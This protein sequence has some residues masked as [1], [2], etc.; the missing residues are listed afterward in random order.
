M[1]DIDD[2][3]SQGMVV[4]LIQINGDLR[5]IADAAR[6]SYASESKTK[7][8]DMK[9]FKYLL[10][11]SHF[12]PFEMVDFI[13]KIQMPLFIARQ[14]YRHRT[15]K[16]YGDELF[17]GYGDFTGAI[18]EMS[19]RYKI[20]NGNFF[21]PLE[22]HKQSTSNKQ[23]SGEECSQEE[24]QR[25]RNLMLASIEQMYDTYCAL[26]DMGVSREEA[27][28]ILPQSSMTHVMAK[29]SFRHFLEFLTLRLAEDAQSD[30]RRLA[31]IMLDAVVIADPDLGEL[32]TEQVD[33][34]LTESKKSV[35]S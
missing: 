16:T 10:S 13:F 31:K 32:L 14:F 1:G 8:E 17:M 30:M 26:I 3:L 25:A 35:N 9:L 6:I 27:R 2:L 34:L 12:T 11:H 24:N 21:I 18:N 19:M 23:C 22:F 20:H 15:I 7:E 29:M 4:K 28:M 5:L 33:S